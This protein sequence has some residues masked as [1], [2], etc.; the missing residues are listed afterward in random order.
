MDW[1]E[2]YWNIKQ[3]NASWDRRTKQIKCQLTTFV[4]RITFGKPDAG[5]TEPTE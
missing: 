2:A 5:E 4:G 1:K 3:K